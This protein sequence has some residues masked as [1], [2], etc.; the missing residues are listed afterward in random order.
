MKRNHTQLLVHYDI[1]ITIMYWQAEKKSNS[2]QFSAILSNRFKVWNTHKKPWGPHA[3]GRGPRMG[4]SFSRTPISMVWIDPS[5]LLTY[6]VL[7]RLWSHRVSA[8]WLASSKRSLVTLNYPDLARELVVEPND[9]WGNS[10]RICLA[11]RQPA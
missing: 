3:R 8:T 9:V 11:L 7:F 4:L 10:H 2:E 6:A 5:Q 1:C